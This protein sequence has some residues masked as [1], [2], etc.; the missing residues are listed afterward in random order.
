MLAACG[1]GS[2]QLRVSLTGDDTHP[3]PYKPGEV[4]TITLDVVNAGPG[5]VSGVTIHATLPSGWHYR[6]TAPFTTPGSTR[7]QPVDAEVNTGT[8]IWGVWTLAQPGAAGVGKPTM[9]S[10]TFY[11]EVQ[12]T[13]GNAQVNAY[14]A[15]DTN[16]GQTDAKPLSLAV[17]AAAQLAALVSVS[18]SHLTKVGASATY[19]VRITNSGTGVAS[20]ISVLVTLPSTVT[21]TSSVLPFTGTAS[22]RNGVDPL[23]NT[24]E[25]YY[26]GFTL[27]PT[28]N[29]GPSFEVIAFKVSLAS[30]TVRGTFPVDC[31]VIDDAG[32]VATLHA[33]APITVP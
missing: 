6:S 13:P 32:D 9:V 26:D 1:S 30:S 19:Q 24:L 25:V 23:K 16:A 7:T 21:F 3:S 5:S 2:G 8:P 15:G 28:S 12:G 11:A 33:V 20:G 29:A 27:G 10:I 4:A 22:R 31:Q 14:A 18:P 17:S